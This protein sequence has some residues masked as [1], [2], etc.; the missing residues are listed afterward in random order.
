[1]IKGWK[2][3]DQW[4]WSDVEGIASTERNS[5]VDGPF[6]SNLKTSDYVEFGI[7]V[8]QG[9]NITG[10]EF[11]WKDIRYI[12]EQ[13]ADELARSSVRV[14]DFLV[15]KIGSIG[16]SAEIK[17]LNGFDHA[18]IPA[19]MAKITI[20]HDQ[21]IS[22]FFAQWL[23]TN[24]VKRHLQS[25]ASKTAQPALSLGKIKSL[26]I[27]LPPIE[28]Q[29]RIAAILDK[30]DAIRQKRKSAL[31]LAD[32]FLRATFLEMFGD[33][34]TNP[35]G[36]DVLPLEK[37]IDVLIGHPFKS[38]EYSDAGVKLCR[39]ANVLPRRL[40]WGDV[41]YWDVER[42]GRYTN[43]ELQESDVIVALDRP[44]ISSGFKIAQVKGTDLPSLLVQRVARLRGKNRAYSDFVYHVLSHKGFEKYCRP[45]ETTVPHISPTELR[46]YPL[47]YPPEELVLKFADVV[48]KLKAISTMDAEIHDD[49]EKLFASLSQRAFKGEL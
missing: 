47:I 49:S 43:Y 21:V 48:S 46:H 2:L 1:M 3:P 28:E 14:G 32:T 35:K 4:R 27:P 16:Y 8:L 37:A 29:R 39:G 36:W 11:S 7:P 26:P 33:P 25:V 19:N 17:S 40:D 9:K 6:G 24:D 34:V 22:N 10:N 23:K 42:S 45:T 44:W 18:I 13:K 20:D 12:S 38:N 31:T 41:R 30:A 5:V 15:I